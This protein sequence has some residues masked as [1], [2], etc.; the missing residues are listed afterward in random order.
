[1]IIEAIGLPGSG[2]TFLFHE[3]EKEFRSNSIRAYNF[4]ELSRNNISVKIVVKL[5]LKFVSLKYICKKWK[6]ELYDILSEELPYES[7]FDLYENPDYCVNYALMLLFIYR[8]FQNSKIVLLL[9][10]GM[11]HNIVKL[12]ADFDFSIRLSNK[13]IEK[14]VLLSRL[15]DSKHIVIYNIFP[16]SETLLSIEKR[17]RHVSKFDELETTQLSKI[18][19]NYDKLNNAIYNN[20]KKQIIS[21]FRKDF[22][23]KNISYIK[24]N[25][26]I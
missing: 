10:E 15:N 17:N 3:L 13:L 1:M 21:V 18:L 7:K 6:K 22:I 25:L 14:C 8:L 2:K 5:L 16:I 23:E 24:Q 12:C 9:D 11:Y 19:D 26:N 4:T 20:D